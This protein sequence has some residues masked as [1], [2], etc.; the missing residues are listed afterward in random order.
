VSLSALWCGDLLRHVHVRC[1]P[2]VK[3]PILR[4]P[5]LCIHLQSAE[6]RR[7]F[8]VNKESHLCPIMSIQNAAEAML[9]DVSS[10]VEGCDPRH[11]PL[12]LRVVAEELGVR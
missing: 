4:I 5:N 10:S 3:R 6:E 12:L 8:T 2:T 7:T 11:A 9:N 1:G